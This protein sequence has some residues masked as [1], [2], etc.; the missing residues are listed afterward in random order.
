[1]T[2]LKKAH[3]AGMD[4]SSFLEEYNTDR[5]KNV[6]ISLTGIHALQKI[7][8]NTK[9]IPIQHVKTFG[10]NMIQN[11]GPLRRQLAIAAAHGVGV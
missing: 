7:F 10:M 8:V 6:S 3:D 9:D 5:H 1:M 2:K 4:L 11:I